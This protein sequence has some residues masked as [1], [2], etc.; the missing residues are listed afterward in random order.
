MRCENGSIAETQK[1]ELVREW[2]FSL[3][4]YTRRS[5]FSAPATRQD[6]P[7]PQSEADELTLEL[8][9]EAEIEQEIADRLETNTLRDAMDRQFG[10]GR[11]SDRRW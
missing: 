6:L 2:K 11:Y 9:L 8:L 10:M 3:P 7:K 1:V 5:T 4:D